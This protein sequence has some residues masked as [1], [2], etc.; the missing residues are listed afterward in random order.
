MKKEKTGFENI[1]FKIIPE[2]EV[3]KE[4]RFV[5]DVVPIDRRRRTVDREKIDS[6]YHGDIE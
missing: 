4:K 6:E 5:G 3:K 2:T 1:N